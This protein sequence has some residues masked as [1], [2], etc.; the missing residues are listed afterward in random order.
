[1]EAIV[2]VSFFNNSC[3]TQ[4][5]KQPKIYQTLPIIGNDS[6]LQCVTIACIGTCLVA[7]WLKNTTSYSWKIQFQKKKH[8]LLSMIW[9]NSLPK[10]IIIV[11]ATNQNTYRPPSKSNYGLV[12]FRVVASKIWEAIPIEVKCLPFNTFKKEYKR[13]LLDSQFQ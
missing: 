13:L 9:F 5:T 6:S 7:I 12:K 3:E 10:F 1:M 11:R 8:L 2:Y 4:V